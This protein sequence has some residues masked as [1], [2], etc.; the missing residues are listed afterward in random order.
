LTELV[1]KRRLQWAARCLRE[2]ARNSAKLKR[3]GKTP[4]SLGR[5]LLRLF[6]TVQRVTAVLDEVGPLVSGS[7]RDLAGESGASRSTRL[8]TECRR[9]SDAYRSGLARAIAGFCRKRAE[10]EQAGSSRRTAWER[11]SAFFEAAA[12]GGSA[13]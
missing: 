11:Q 9:V 7:G 2:V 6:N 13:R 10:V 3:A 4:T 8:L 12:A 1:A 5:D